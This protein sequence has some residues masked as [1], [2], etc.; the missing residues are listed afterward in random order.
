VKKLEKEMH[1]CARNLEFER[2]ADLRDKLKGLKH[3]LFGVM[4]HD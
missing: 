2:A 1:E 4:E 3:L